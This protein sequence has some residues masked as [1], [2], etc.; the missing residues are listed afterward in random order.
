MTELTLTRPDAELR[1]TSTGT[2]PTVLLLHAGG[3]TRDVWT[4]VAAVLNKHQQLLRTV[5]YDLRGHGDSSGQA[6]ELGPIAADVSAMIHSEPPPIVVVGASLGGLAAIAS[7]AAPPTAQAVA[8]LI[9]V[10]VVP[11]PDIT[12][13]RA[14][15]VD[16]G[17][18]THAPLVDDIFD[19]IPELQTTATNLNLPIHLVRG[20]PTSPHTDA[21]INR[22][23]TT[24]PALT[25]TQLPT[26]GHL[27]AHDA[28]DEL[29][30]IIATQTSAWLTTD[31]TPAHR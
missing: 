18:R 26:A 3:E 9:L 16:R 29:A 28:P 31:P 1:G 23:R 4:P 13:V 2:G 7:L 22:F 24:N 8:G 17:L 5:A 15:L 12:R 19:Q 10:D 25:I 14:W 21:D 27:I 11:T 20:G 30:R 6:T